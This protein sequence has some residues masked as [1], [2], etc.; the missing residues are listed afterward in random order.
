MS[1]TSNQAFD[2]ADRFRKFSAAIGEY[3]SK[4]RDRLSDTEF[5]KL[6]KLQVDI[7]LRSMKIRTKA[8]GLLLDEADA[9]LKRLNEVTK[10]A[11]A[12]IKAIDNT[13]KIISIATSVFE[14]GVAVASGK[15]G[16]IVKK[17]GGVTKAL[18]QNKKKAKKK[19]T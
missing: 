12:T 11:R 16:E 14:L 15:P 10:Q 6:D 19:S 7:L 1:L 5:D 9:S 2:L 8:V 13:K 18:K 3:K 17:L 4:H